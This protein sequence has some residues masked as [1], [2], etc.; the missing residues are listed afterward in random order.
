MGI[1]EKILGSR[2]TVETV[3]LE[4][5]LEE[6][7]NIPQDP[8]DYYV[9]KLALRNEGDAETVIKAVSEKKIVILDVTPITKQPNK[10]KNMINKFKSHVSRNGGDIAFLWDPLILLTPPNVKIVKAKKKAR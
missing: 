5:V 10:L 2:A 9:V 6:L 7:E 4:S 8:A 1:M 3:E